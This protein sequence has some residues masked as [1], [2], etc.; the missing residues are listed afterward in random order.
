M[1]EQDQDFSPAVLMRLARAMKPMEL[2]SG[3]EAARQGDI[4]L[5]V[6]DIVAVNLTKKQSGPLL[7]PHSQ[8]SALSKSWDSRRLGIRSRAVGSS[9]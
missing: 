2:D 1:S 9:M 7:L 3:H 4:V 8:T 6:G 5:Q